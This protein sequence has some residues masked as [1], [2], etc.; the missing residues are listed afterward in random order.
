MTEFLEQSVVIQDQS[1]HEEFCLG[2]LNNQVKNQMAKSKITI[3]YL[4]NMIK[5]K[6]S[7]FL[8]N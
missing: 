4:K 7:R 8:M 2:L 1:R 3:T 6:S 5:E